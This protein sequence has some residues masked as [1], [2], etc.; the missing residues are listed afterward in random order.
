MHGSRSVFHSGTAL[1]VCWGMKLLLLASLAYALPL[2]LSAS[3]QHQLLDHCVEGQ[4]DACLELATAARD[5]YAASKALTGVGPMF[6][7]HQAAALLN[8]ACD[9]GNLDACADVKRQIGG[10][11]TWVEQEDCARL[12]RQTKSPAT[13]GRPEVHRLLDG[14]GENAGGMRTVDWRAEGVFA[15]GEGA[16]WALDGGA[17]RELAHLGGHADAIMPIESGV[18]LYVDNA[19][20]RVGP[21]GAQPVRVEGDL[22]PCGPGAFVG[23]SSAHVAAQAGHCNEGGVLAKVWLD[24]GRIRS[25][26]TFSEDVDGPIVDVDAITGRIAV[27]SML[28]AITWT[29]TDPNEDDALV[30]HPPPGRMFEEIALSPDGAG[31][32]FV[33]DEG[34]A[35]FAAFAAPEDRKRLAEASSGLSFHPS[36]QWLAVGGLGSVRFSSVDGKPKGSHR[37]G[38]KQ[39]AQR[40]LAFSP[41]GTA[42]FT[43]G[44]SS[45]ILSIAGSQWNEVVAPWTLPSSSQPKAAEVVDGKARITLPGRQTGTL[46]AQEEGRYITM[47]TPVR[48]EGLWELELPPGEYTLLHSLDAT[49]RRCTLVLTEATAH[50][51]EWVMP[52]R[53]SVRF[54]DAAGLG[55][56]G[57]KLRWG[58][59]NPPHLHIEPTTGSDGIVH[60]P[61]LGAEGRLTLATSVPGLL[62]LDIVGELPGTVVATAADD[63]ASVPLPRLAK[64][65]AWLPGSWSVQDKVIDIT[66]QTWDDIEFAATDRVGEILIT[67]NRSAGPWKKW[68]RGRV[69]FV[70]RDT[71]V[72]V[73]GTTRRE[74]SFVYRRTADP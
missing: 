28:S 60:L 9:L 63:G 57:I 14:R 72:V 24:A 46:I 69:R 17:L 42:L 61:D 15:A 35:W 33:D 34:V 27:A 1:A 66:S 31:L 68:S 62:P 52:A 40:P 2:A 41:D 43:A 4:A 36:G 50:Q 45:H 11:K 54:E 3:Q 18:L 56:A 67:K 37:V 65:R 7:R 64:W 74:W 70:D 25:T 10:C 39:F 53:R 12:L 51:S 8:H 73:S 55:I 47:G 58:L 38:H 30:L 29:T 32:A 48:G 19:F 23:G 44:G 26:I 59:V 71:M 16:V 21:E 6:R 49:I 20:Q 5:A 22:L 13:W